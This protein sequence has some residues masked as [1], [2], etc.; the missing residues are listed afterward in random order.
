MGDSQAKQILTGLILF[1]NLIQ[2]KRAFDVIAKI[3]E[4]SI[5]DMNHE[6]G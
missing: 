6:I 5:A 3:S 1:A 4:E 2:K